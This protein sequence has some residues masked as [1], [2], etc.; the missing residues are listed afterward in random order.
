MR[1]FV[2]LSQCGNRLLIP[3]KDRVV[4]GRR[5]PLT[6]EIPDVDM[7][8][9][10]AEEYGI[11]RQHAAITQRDG[12]FSIED[13]NST[14]ATFVNRRKLNQ[15]ESRH[16]KIGDEIRLGRITFIFTQK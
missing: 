14:N 6:D 10:G 8:S 3:V 2:L 13:L 11:S 7:T 9:L 15:S 5:D 16:L 1:D 12:D 4:L